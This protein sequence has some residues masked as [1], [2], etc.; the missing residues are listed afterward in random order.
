[1]YLTQTLILFYYLIYTCVIF[2]FIFNRGFQRDK[3]HFKGHFIKVN[4]LY[5]GH[6]L[7]TTHGQLDHLFYYIECY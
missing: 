1:M 4:D 6:L 3:Y 2:L 7:P 5:I